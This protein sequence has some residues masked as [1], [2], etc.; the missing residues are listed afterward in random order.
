[1]VDIITTVISFVLSWIVS[2]VIIY[3]VA[4]FFGEK[5][6]IQTAFIAALVGAIIYGLAYYF[7]GQGTLASVLGGVG[8]LLAIGMLYK[9]GWVKALIIAIVVWFVALIIGLF[10]PTLAG[11]I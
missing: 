2:G 8:W 1:M 3:F 10:L 4:K 9:V 5:E 6:K 11:P 7:L